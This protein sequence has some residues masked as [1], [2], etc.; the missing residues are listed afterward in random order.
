MRP[1]RRSNTLEVKFKDDK[2]AFSLGDNCT[3]LWNILTYKRRQ[4]FWK[5]KFTWASKRE[6][7]AFKKL[8]GSAT[9]QQTIRKNDEAWRSF[10]RQ[11]KLLKQGTL[12]GVTYAN[13]PGYWKDKQGNRIPRIIIRND[14]YTINGQRL[15]LPLGLKGRVH[16]KPEWQ[17][18]QGTLTLK[19]DALDGQ[20]N[21]QQSMVVTRPRF[22]KNGERAFVDIGVRCIIAGWTQDAKQVIAYSGNPL[23]ADWWYQTSRITQLQRMLPKGQHTSH[24]IQCLYRLR[25]RRFHQ[26]VNSIV[27]DYTQRCLNEN[28]STI[29][30]GDLKHVLDNNN[31]TAPVNAML[32]NFWS[33]QYILQRLKCTAENHGIRVRTRSE[34][35]TSSR[36]P[37]CRSKHVQ[38]RKRLF[39]C[40]S[41]GREAH[42]DVVGAL[43]I[44]LV[45]C[46]ERGVINRVMTHPRLIQTRNLQVNLEESPDL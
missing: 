2:R 11:L 20:W 45:S 33:N 10:F 13:P 36:C 8:I 16:G 35:G 25:Q 29:V 43:N 31:H 38:K 30:A 23:L 21:A 27:A 18:K 5:H 39:R 17:G 9:A 37:W 34:R 22:R 19:H 15:K 28:V 4:S 1:H 40:L 41:C 3:I 14:C 24:H 42:R 6:Y 7:N 26:A 32:H 46:K 44:G 12:K